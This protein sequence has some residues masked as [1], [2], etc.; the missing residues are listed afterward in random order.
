MSLP[1]SKKPLRL[2]HVRSAFSLVLLLLNSAN[3]QSVFSTGIG[4]SLGLLY[5]TN[6]GTGVS[7]TGNFTIASSFVALTL[8]PVDLGIMPQDEDARYRSETF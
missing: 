7:L 8:T 2:T 4:G 6:D 5:T 3:A 1:E